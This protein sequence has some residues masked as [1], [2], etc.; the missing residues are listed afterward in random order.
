MSDPNEIFHRLRAAADTDPLPDLKTR[1]SWLESLRSAV[2]NR[3]GEIRT[4]VWEDFR[5]SPVEADLTESVPVLL[6]LRTALRNV[7]SW[8]APTR[9]RNVFPLWGLSSRLQHHPKG[10]VVILSPWNYPVNLSLGPLVSALAAGN[11][12]IIKPSERVPHTSH[13][14]ASLV[15]DALPDH[16]ATV[17]EGGAEVGAEL[18]NL[19]FDHFYFTGGA[20]VGT[21]V[22]RAAARHLSSVTLELGG[23]SPAVVDGSVDLD[24]CA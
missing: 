23:K 2:L 15:G 21:E 6:E 22:M 9:L 10:V 11:R 20:G 19:P 5:K 4:A 17:V 18:L 24:Q 16:V 13:L 8:T 12:A 1:I 3:R 7:A 14:L